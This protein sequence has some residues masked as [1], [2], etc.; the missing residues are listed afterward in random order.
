MDLGAS[1]YLAA[2]KGDSLRVRALVAQGADLHAKPVRA[3]PFGALRRG[4]EAS[5]RSGHRTA[6]GALGDGANVDAA[7]ADC[8][9]HAPL[10]PRP[11]RA[12]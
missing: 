1:L 10:T 3:L 5:L 6:V 12:P 7:T 2:K 4:I 11:P 8:T 9:S